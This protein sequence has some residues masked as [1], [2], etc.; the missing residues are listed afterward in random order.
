MK[1]LD[2]KDISERYMDLLNPTS[3]EKILKAGQIAGMKPGDRL[4][5]FG[6]GLRQS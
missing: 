5:D 6:C 1:F 3:P 4:I 2:L